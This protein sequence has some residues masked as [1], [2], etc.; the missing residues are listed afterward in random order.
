METL[1]LMRQRH[2]VRQY[3]DKPIPEETKKALL[4]LVEEINKESN[5]NFQLFF[6]EP[7]AFNTLMAHYGKFSGV[8]NYLALVSDDEEK[9]GYYGEKFVLE[10][11][12]LGLNSCWVAM[13]YGKR[14][15]KIISDGKQ[16]LICVIAFGYGKNSGIPHRSKEVS[17]VLKII[18]EKPDYLDLAAE[19]CLLAPTGMNQQKFIITSDNGKITISINGKG[20]YTKIDLGIVKYHFAAITE[21]KK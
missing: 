11:Q 18:G 13:T 12:R 2:S 10:S 4:S 21:T 8:K 19:A 6:E 7:E 3:S 16:K 20:F 9:A 1:E 17:S 15:V 14:K 5:Q